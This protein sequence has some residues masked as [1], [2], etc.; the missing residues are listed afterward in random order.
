M[1]L[2]DIKPGQKAVLKDF[3]SNQSVHFKLLS[4]GVL[5]GDEVEVMGKAPFGGPIS[6]KH[7]NQTFF[8]LRRNEAKLI[9]VRS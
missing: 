8:A 3:S 5:P 6:I 1:K 9:E 4:L 7:G 2:L